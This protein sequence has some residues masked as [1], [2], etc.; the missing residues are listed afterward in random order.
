M[1]PKHMVYLADRESAECLYCNEL[2]SMGEWIRCTE[3]HIACSNHNGDAFVNST[4]P[5][6]KPKHCSMM[7]TVFTRAE[8]YRSYEI[9][10]ILY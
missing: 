4:M 3:A 7:F 6:C 9:I 10:Q 5:C 8:Q 1:A 2:F